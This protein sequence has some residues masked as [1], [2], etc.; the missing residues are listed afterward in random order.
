MQTVTLKI[1][2]T[3]FSKVLDA[4][5]FFP[6]DKLKI[7]GDNLTNEELTNFSKDLRMAFEEIAEIE[8]GNRLAKTWQEVRNA[9]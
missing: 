7:F 8:T 2:D 4:L 3:I 6:K 1:D 5:S 9:L